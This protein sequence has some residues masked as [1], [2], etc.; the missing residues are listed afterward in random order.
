MK[1]NH[2]HDPHATNAA[3]FPDWTN[4]LIVWGNV[5]QWKRLGGR[6][7]LKLFCAE[8]GIAR[9]IGFQ[10]DAAFRLGY[11]ALA[12]AS[13]EERAACSRWADVKAL[14]VAQEAARQKAFL[15]AT[16]TRKAHCESQA[17]KPG[18]LLLAG[19]N[20]RQIASGTL[21]TVK[22]ALPLVIHERRDATAKV[23]CWVILAPD[24]TEY[25][26]GKFDAEM[27]W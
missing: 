27:V 12:A 10:A 16:H 21:R 18:W 26:A 14:R 8:A 9:Q 7:A 17:E 11:Y 13:P 4:D 25:L 15:L 19:E 1:S 20:T 2:G 5:R 23:G 22:D 3:N 6:G 24:G